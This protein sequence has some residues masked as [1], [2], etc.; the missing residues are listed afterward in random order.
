LEVV[1][2]HCSDHRAA[3]ER[4]GDGRPQLDVVRVLAHDRELHER[5]AAGFTAPEAVEA[6]G[7]CPYTLVSNVAH[8]VTDELVEATQSHARARPQ[9]GS[10]TARTSECIRSYEPL[11]AAGGLQFVN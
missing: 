10:D 5:I 2:E 6:V 4:Q 1:G 8:I 9:D 11:E 7:L 3:S